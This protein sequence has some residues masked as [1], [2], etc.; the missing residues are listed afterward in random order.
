MPKQA[1]LHKVGQEGQVVGGNT[2]YHTVMYGRL[3][4]SEFV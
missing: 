3:K 1:S 2:C 4:R